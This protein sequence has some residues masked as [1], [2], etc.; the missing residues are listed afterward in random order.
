MDVLT[1]INYG[2]RRLTAFVGAVAATALVCA[3]W[4]GVA[5][6]AK[7]SAASATLELCKDPGGG[8]DHLP[9]TI[10]T[11][12]TFSL[13]QGSNWQDVVVPGG[14]CVE[15]STIGSS[16]LVGGKVVTVTEQALSGWQFQGVVADPAHADDLDTSMTTA[17]NAKF[18]VTIAGGDMAT[19]TVTN[20]L[21]ASSIKVCKW[22]NAYAGSTYSFTVGTQTVTAKA[23]S[24]P[25]DPAGVC[26]G[27]VSFQI[28]SKVKITEAVPS[29]ETS[30]ITASPAS[31]IPTPL[32]GP[33]A[34]PSVTV[35]TQAGVNVITF[36]NEPIGPPQTGT[37]EVCKYNWDGF[38]H[39]D[40]FHF[41]VTSVDGNTS[42]DSED[43]LVGQCTGA[44]TVPAGPVLV[45]ETLP[46]DNSVVLDHVE[47]DPSSALGLV[48][49]NNG[50]AIVNVPVANTTDPTQSN[51]DVVCA[52]W[53]NA[54][55]AN[56]KVCKVLAAGSGILAG[57]RFSFKVHITFPNGDDDWA[58]VSIVAN[59]SAGGACVLLHDQYPVG[60][61]VDVWE[62]L[63]GEAW[64][65]N[66]YQS[67]PYVDGGN[68]AGVNVKKSLDSLVGG[69]NTI[70]FTNQA[71]G[72]L[73]ICKD[74]VDD[75]GFSQVPFTI[76]YSQ[77]GGKTKGSVT[78]AD[79]TC[80]QPQIVP[81]GNYSISETFPTVKVDQWTKLQAYQF[82]ASDA[83]GPLSDNRC[84]PQQSGV[85]LAEG[86]LSHIQWLNSLAEGPG[87][88]TNCGLPLTVS[89]PYFASSDPVNFGETDVEIWNKAVLA[90]L[91]ICKKITSDSTAALSSLTFSFEYT[92]NGEESDT[93][94]VKAGTCS[95]LL[96]DDYLVGFPIF[97]PNLLT[98]N[99]YLIPT[100]VT[101]TET[102]SNGTGTCDPYPNAFH[103]NAVT[104]TG[105]YDGEGFGTPGN[106]GTSTP[107]NGLNEQVTKT[108]PNDTTVDFYPGA[109]PNVV[110]YWDQSNECDL[111]A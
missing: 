103:V 48:N 44:I 6:A 39:G 98:S 79:G 53:N 69:T 29:G 47:C 4:A 71:L 13:K 86:W 50:T 15:I 42:Y 61:S 31:L 55:L 104:L 41:D 66:W 95:G 88:I 58:W 57:Q 23:G 10:G 81:I 77:V 99:G 22:S 25:G 43:V 85:P 20:T 19:V 60:S 21:P 100:E 106:F 108:A 96:T 24:S 63:A 16:A 11:N 30:Q 37:L 87:S 109:G 76:S 72:Q 68:G 92:V 33:I 110:T 40:T 56:V 51:G 93:V 35:K 101:V 91:K 73:E 36:E 78:V 2:P 102:G 9:S 28:G 84:V 64:S 89:V 70:S 75:T 45:S 5:S 1:G 83:R 12:F 97:N 14:Q 90:Q 107:K 65:G 3:L 34:G 32:G 38:L 17:K 74:V 105:G 26:S 46:D 111:P 49:K 62:N 27:L 80:S 18:Q 8:H 52:F 82:V 59:T 7:P 54:Q 67:Y 94:Y